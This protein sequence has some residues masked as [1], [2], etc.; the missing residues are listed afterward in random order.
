MAGVVAKRAAHI[1]A[2]KL[3]REAEASLSVY[4]KEALT[5]CVRDAC[6]DVQEHAH[7]Q[8]ILCLQE[9]GVDLEPLRSITLLKGGA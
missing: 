5:A 9:A 2:A 1:W 7:R 3:T 8:F 6:L 4:D